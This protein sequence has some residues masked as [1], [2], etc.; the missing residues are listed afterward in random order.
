LIDTLQRGVGDGTIQVG[1]RGATR[2]HSGEIKGSRVD[3]DLETAG[4]IEPSLTDA[5]RIL[6]T[7]DEPLTLLVAEGDG[8]LLVFGL[9]LGD[10]DGI[11]SDTLFIVVLGHLGIL[12]VVLGF[13]FSP[14][15]PR[16]TAR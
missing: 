3:D 5:D 13:S 14:H 15:S 6:H 2:S 12:V 1:V 9:F 7:L 16:H 10:P 11:T 8:S 4:V